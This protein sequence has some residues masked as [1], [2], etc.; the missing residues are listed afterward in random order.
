MQHEGRGVIRMHDQTSHGGQVIGASSGTTVMGLPAALAGDMTHC[1]RCRG[2]FP[3]TPDGA[4][5]RH[6][7]RPYAY[8]GDHTACGARLMTSL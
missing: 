8:D 5:A 4:G 3:I 1:P 6:E 7:G 2:N